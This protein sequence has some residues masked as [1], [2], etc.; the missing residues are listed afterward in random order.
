MEKSK[1]AFIINPNSGTSKKEDLPA[2]IDKKLDKSRYEA[3]VVFT[4]Y[5]GHGKELAARFVEE[6]YKYVVACG[7]DGTMNEVASEL[8]HTGVIFGV[9][10]YGSGNGLARHLGIS[11]FPRRALKQINN[12][13]IKT[14]DYGLADETKFFCTC[15]TGFDAH[16]SHEFATK[17]RRGFLTYLKTIFKEYLHYKPYMYVLKNEEVEIRQRA[18]LITFANASQY[19]NNAFIAPRASTSDGILD[20]TILKPFSFFAIPWLAFLLFQK[21]IDRSK[22][23]STIRTKEIT[24]IRRKAGLF[25]IDGD[26][27]EKGKEIHIKVI[28]AGLKV[29]IGRS[30]SIEVIIRAQLI[31]A[32]RKIRIHRKSIQ[33]AILE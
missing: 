25:H 14:I 3:T 20:V 21:E 28:P 26:P 4:Q 15:G 13:V 27:V 22:H 8:V 2:L 32:R 10:P 18:F 1:I 29:L 33:R 30:L 7:G 23:I 12:H 17:G 6:K 19:G 5:A 24:L 9:I 11:M 16:V 31:Y